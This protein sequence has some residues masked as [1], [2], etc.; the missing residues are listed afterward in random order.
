MYERVRWD[1]FFKLVVSKAGAPLFNG[2][3]MTCELRVKTNPSVFWGVQVGDTGTGIFVELMEVKERVQ[4]CLEALCK[5]WA[6]LEYGAG[7]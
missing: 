2:F 3:E 6:E 1:P 4:I 7:I 5:I